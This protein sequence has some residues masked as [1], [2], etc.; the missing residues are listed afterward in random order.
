MSASIND[1][2]KLIKSQSKPQS[3]EFHRVISALECVLDNQVDTTE[4]IASI[5]IWNKFT[6]VYLNVVNHGKTID[7]VRAN[8]TELTKENKMLKKQCQAWENN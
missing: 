5:G 6:S 7:F 4:R 3:S 2:I 8:V 1:V